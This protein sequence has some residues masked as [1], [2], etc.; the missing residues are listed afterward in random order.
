MFGLGEAVRAIRE[1]P[2]VRAQSDG[3]VRG[4]A[5]NANGISYAVRFAKTMRVVA[6]R[7]LDATES[8]K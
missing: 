1:L 6:E 7:D 5:K 8:A 3:I 2:G 4:I